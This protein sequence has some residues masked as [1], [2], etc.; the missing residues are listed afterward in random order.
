M[1]KLNVC[2]IG[3]AIL[4][5]AVFSM[6]CVGAVGP[7]ITPKEKTVSVKYIRVQPYDTQ[8][9]ERVTL[10]WEYPNYAG[11]QGMTKQAEDTFTAGAL[12]RTETRITMK[13]IDWWK[14]NYVCKRIFIENQELIF[15][16][17]EFGWVQFI[18]HNDGKIKV[19]NP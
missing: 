18:Y 11:A 12:I 13:I 9:S 3:F 5:I 16:G 4:V 8:S 14:P 19:I 1:K 17:T 2:L 7:D 10:N 15:P 6:T